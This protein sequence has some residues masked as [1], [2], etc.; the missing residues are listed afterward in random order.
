[1]CTDPTREVDSIL[2]GYARRW[3]VEVLFFEIKQH[4][5]SRA[6]LN[7]PFHVASSRGLMT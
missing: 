3:S 6:K 5:G 1:M 2:S 7:C 4:L